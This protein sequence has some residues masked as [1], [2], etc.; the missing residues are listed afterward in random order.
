M[1]ENRL[2]I[3][4]GNDENNETEDNTET[5]SSGGSQPDAKFLNVLRKADRPFAKTGTFADEVGVHQRTALKRL[6]KLEKAGRVESEQ[7]G[8]PKIWWL[9][10]NEPTEPVGESGARILRLSNKLSEVVEGIRSLWRDFFAMSG[11][12]LLVILTADSQGIIFPVLGN[13]GVAIIA[14]I[15]ALGAGGAVG[16][17]GLLIGFNMFL[18]SALSRGWIGTIEA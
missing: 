15:L 12:L 2:E 14:Y 10:E 1:T 16:L 13:E 9:D 4:T 3:L 11:F 6:N 7:I 17:W 8:Q 18:R 5:N